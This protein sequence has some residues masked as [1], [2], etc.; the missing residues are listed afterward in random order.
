MAGIKNKIKN[1]VDEMNE[2][3]REDVY[4]RQGLRHQQYDSSRFVRGSSDAGGK[5]FLRYCLQ[6]TRT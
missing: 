2:T 4:K 1:I 6:R 3:I 5:Q